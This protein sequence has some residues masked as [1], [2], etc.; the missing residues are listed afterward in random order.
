[1]ELPLGPQ[2][3][4]AHL[5]NSIARALNVQDEK[6]NAME[7]VLALIVALT[8]LLQHVDTDIVPVDMPCP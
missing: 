3:R 6:S 5:E 7:G 2:Q 1:V 8:N 4:T